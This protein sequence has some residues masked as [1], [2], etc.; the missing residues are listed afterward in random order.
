MTMPTAESRAHTARFGTQTV[1]TI[2]STTWLISH[3]LKL[4]YP[5]L[6]T[7]SIPTPDVMQS[8]AGKD[9]CCVDNVLLF[10]NIKYEKFMDEVGDVMKIHYKHLSIGF[11]FGTAQKNDPISNIKNAETLA[12]MFQD[13]IPLALSAQ[14]HHA[15]PFKVEI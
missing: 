1:C 8:Q 3:I 12:Q 14:K 11:R 13:E 10:S 2:I 6:I 5:T 7:F 9:V 4:D 15:K